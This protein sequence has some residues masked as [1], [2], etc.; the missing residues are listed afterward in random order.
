MLDKDFSEYGIW[1][2]DDQVFVLNHTKRV[3]NKMGIDKIETASNG[4]DALRFLDNTEELPQLMICDLNMP[5]MDGVALLRH[6]G[7]RSI[8]MGIIFVSGE[9][10]RILQIAEALGKSHDLYILGSI[11]KPIKSEPLVKLLNNFEQDKT[12]LSMR[13]IVPV[14]EKELLAG[15]SGDAVELV[16]QP[17]VSI[18]KKRL[19]GVEALARWRHPGRGILGP[20]A[21]IPLAEE[22][23]QIDILTDTV[24]RKAMDQGGKWR[25][26]DSDIGI[27][28]NYSVDSLNRLDLPEYIISVAEEQGMDPTRVTIEVTETRCMRDINSIV[29]ILTRM[30]LKGLGLS[31][32]DFG[33]GHSTME[34]LKRIPFTELKI[35]R[36][37]VYGASD[38]S[39]TRAILESSVSLG[40]SFDLKLV[41]E[42]AETQDD[43]NLVAA[44][45]CDEV[46]GYFVAKPMAGDDILTWKE[47]W[48]Q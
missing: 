41:A 11:Q 3:L 16:Y 9:D 37:F 40:K 4:E 21:F 14:T 8:K 35:D 39:S 12:A 45:G 2:V 20:G 27:S 30:R 15:I 43:W 17:K 22:L 6:L 5:G 32:D 25:A 33:T 19:I 31:I 13:R 46:Q 28:I 34:Q 42:G 36:A 29:E 1:L 18:S 24:L 23:G 38:D 44:L 26:E 47:T 7:E 48:E 10:H